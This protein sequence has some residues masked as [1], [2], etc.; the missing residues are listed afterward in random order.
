M[1]SSQSSFVMPL[2]PLIHVGCIAFVF[3]VLVKLDF[4]LSCG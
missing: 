4:G 1:L 3:I 2:S